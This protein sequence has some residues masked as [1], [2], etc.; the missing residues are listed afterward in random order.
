LTKIR[1][2]AL[3][4]SHGS[5]YGPGGPLNFKGDRTTGLTGSLPSFDNSPN[6]TEV[7]L[8]YNNISGE[9]PSN[10]LNKVSSNED[11]VIDLS[12]NKISGSLPKPLQRF[13]YMTIYLSGNQIDSIDESFCSLDT[14]MEGQVEERG[15]NAILCPKG[16]YNQYGRETNEHC[17]DCAF[18]FSA[19]F[20]GSGECMADL[21]NYNEREILM[22]LFDATSGPEWMDSENWNKDDVS[23][24]DWHGIFCDSEELN[25][26]E[27]VVKEINL[28]SNKLVGTIPPQVF[29]L[30][31]LKVLNVR[32]NKIDIQLSSL[33]NGNLGLNALYIDNTLISSLFGIG[34]LKNLR[35]LHAQQNNF[36]GKPLPDE[37]FT[38]TKLKLL[39]ISD[40]N[41]GGELSPSIGGLSSLEEFFWYVVFSI[42]LSLVFVTKA[43][44]NTSSLSQPQ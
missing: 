1:T 38:L 10:F 31:H 3:Q 23:I 20:Y 28:P 14:W 15:C 4:H 27:E 6:L 40:S 24:C 13:S 11:I 2:I 18:T 21:T 29:G 34:R 19:P 9:I 35:T 42:I 36:V 41:I 25:G 37:I 5:Q 12:M 43:N 30:Q 8:G 32:D 39:Y 44:L 26:G 7:Y 17:Q 16:T 33:T 22:K